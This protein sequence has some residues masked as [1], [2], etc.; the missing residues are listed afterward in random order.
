MD[1]FLSKKKEEKPYQARSKRNIEKRGRAVGAQI[2]KL[3]IWR[4]ITKLRASKILFDNIFFISRIDTD[5]Y[6]FLNDT[7]TLYIRVKASLI[8]ENNEKLKEA[9]DRE[10]RF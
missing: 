2:L 3:Y 1:L 8:R 4:R 7:T 5:K 6:C 10:P 9:S